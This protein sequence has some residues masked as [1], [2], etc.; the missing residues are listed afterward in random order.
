MLTKIERFAKDLKKEY[1]SLTKRAI[2]RV[3]KATLA[4]ADFVSRTRKPVRRIADT[5][6]KLN[7]ISHKSVEK[8]VKQQAI[9]VDS[10]IEGGAKNL[11]L[12][13]RADNL[14]ELVGDQIATLP[15][16]RS[17]A[18]KNALTTIDIVRETGGEIGGVF[19]VAPTKVKTA[20]KK[21]ARKTTAA[22]KG[23]TKRVAKTT[24]K[25]RKTATA[26]TASAKKATTRTVRKT[27]RAAKANVRKIVEAAPRAAA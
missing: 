22:R 21:V 24:T 4:T 23:A 3:R 25:A 20:R 1:G 19:R 6:I 9:V 18:G 27:G 26:R 2:G 5:G 11:K 12:A 17:W 8:L 13:A 14:R 16:A 7:R 10:A 15:K